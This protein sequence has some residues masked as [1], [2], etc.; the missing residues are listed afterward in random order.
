MPHW[1]EALL[2]LLTQFTGNHGGVDHIV[3]NYG[4]AAF[5]YSVLFAIAR[6]KYREDPQSRERWLMWGF[7]FGLGRELFML[8][9]A[10][11]LA[12][13]F[14]QNADLHVIFP[15]FEH[16]L[17]SV[18]LV[19]I[20]ASFL[21]YLIDDESLSRRYLQA[22][23]AAAILMYAITAVPWAHHLAANPSTTFG[24]SIYDN[25]WHANASLWLAIATYFLA[26][27]TQGRVR[28]Y[29]VLALVLFFLYEII[30]IPDNM[31]GERYEHT[32]SPFRILFYL[33]AI[34]V[35]GYVY[36]YEQAEERKKYLHNLEGLVHERTIELNKRSEELKVALNAITSENETLSE[37]SLTDALTGLNN[38]R[39]FDSSL[40]AEW[41]R[42]K[43]DL[44]SLS[45]LMIDLD[46]FKSI[47]DNY[48]HSAGDQW[49]QAV[50]NVLKTC[51][52]RPTDIVTRYAGDEFMILLPNTDQ[53]GAQG[54][55]E[56]IQKRVRKCE[57][58]LDGTGISLS[59]TVSIGIASAYPHLENNAD[60]Q[61]N[62]QALV[63]Q[64]D[65]A[66]Y[67]A[68]NDGRNK[69]MTNM[70][71]FNPDIKPAN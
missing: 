55:A 25:I 31:L 30:K 36:V 63:K 13:G 43:R 3:V 19:I 12:L 15:P 39:F 32:I 4:I 60:E 24:K 33:M 57:V 35:L 52:R 62:Q 50:A 49:L 71:A 54:V 6:A 41:A 26:T 1:F 37:Q 16:L 65:A 38:R 58:E 9:M 48:G 45:I 64:A 20:A 51:L 8:L 46:F 29:V 23:L 11:I 40:N 53:A 66:L 44:T 59:G 27:R 14:V 47:N 56:Q 61:T 10:A 7:A 67:Q 28:N 34:P 22:G 5:F 70:K 21:R 17:L 2:K 18:A 68:K 69:T 42:A